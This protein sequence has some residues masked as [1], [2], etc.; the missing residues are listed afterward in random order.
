MTMRILAL[1]IRQ[2][3][4]VVLAR[5]RARQIAGLLGFPLLDQTRIATATSEIARNAY[6]YAGGGKAEFLVEDAAPQCLVVRVLERGPGI[7]NLQAIL[8]GDYVSPTGLGLGI[9][10]ARRLMDRFDIA[11]APGSGATVTMAK[12]L[13]KRAVGLSPQELSRVS[14]ELARNAPQ[15][16]LDELQQ[17]NQELMRT[18]QELRD[19][20]TEVME[21]HRRELEETNRG[22]VALFTELDENAKALQRVSD[23]K[24]RFL[25]NMSHEFRSPL[26]TILTLSGFL[27]DRSDGELTE[28]QEKQVVFIRKA[29][30]GLSALVNDLLDLAKVEAGKAVVRPKSFDVAELFTGLR[31]TIR[32]L[33]VKSSVSLRF[34]EPVGVAALRTD[35]GKLG[36]ILRNFLSNAVKFTE[37]GEIRVAATPGPGETVIF[38]VSDTGVG[39]APGDRDRIFEEFGQVENPLQ[40]RVKGT[41]LGLPLSRKLAELLGGNISVKSEPGVGST[42][43]AV[44]PRVYHEPGDSGADPNERWKLDPGRLPLLAVE[45]DPVDMILYEK[46]LQGSDFQVLPARTLDEARRVLRRV[47]PVAVLLDILLD[48]ESGW[49]LLTELKSQESTRDVPVLVMTVVDGQE[50][51]LALGADHFCLKPVDQTWLLDRL[52]ALTEKGPVEKVLIIDDTESD[53]R[54]LRELLTAGGQYRIVEAR[55]GEEGLRRARDDHPSVIFLDLVMQDMTGLEV[56]DRL[57]HDLVTSDIPVIIHTSKDLGDDERKRL[58]VDA[59]AILEKSVGTRQEAFGRIREALIKAGLN[60]VSVGEA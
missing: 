48:V 34:E 55:D 14:A 47:R 57:K 11:T 43:F 54:L 21:L 33:L 59:A 56:L 5:Q 37:W 41:G 40:G 3:P 31:G 9:I 58:S 19:R 36:Q 35:E 25:S 7:E 52:N 6:Q 29:A 27:L 15:G 38:S 50:R 2:E 30:D 51:A 28:E 49:T 10:G 16:L 20:Q 42:F 12:N 26:N 4:D 46:I 39:I 8:D 44:I 18:L 32:P 53:R 24:S 13:P 17:Q 23:L 45:D 60:L 1:E 22:V